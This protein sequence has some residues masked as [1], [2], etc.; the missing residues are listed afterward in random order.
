MWGRDHPPRS[1]SLPRCLPFAFVADLRVAKLSESARGCSQYLPR[2]KFYGVN[3]ENGVFGK[4]EMKFTGPS[5]RGAL[6]AWSPVFGGLLPAHTH[7]P[8]RPAP[9]HGRS[10]DRARAVLL[11]STS[12]RL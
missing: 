8:R 10:S 5:Q 9:P 2:L 4:A 11:R 12:P 7:C 1:R 3:I 6:L